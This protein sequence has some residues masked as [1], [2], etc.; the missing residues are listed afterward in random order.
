[1]ARLITLRR[2]MNS[3]W[4]SDYP[5][6]TM[7][8]QLRRSKLY[9]RLKWG[10]RMTLPVVYRPAKS[11]FRIHATAVIEWNHFDT[12][13]SSHHTNRAP[14]FNSSKSHNLLL[15][16]S[17]FLYRKAMRS[18]EASSLSQR[19]YFAGFS[20]IDDGAGNMC[21]RWNTPQRLDQR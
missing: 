21:G 10:F 17:Q 7:R 20:Y 2:T 19:R 16:V 9:S 8:N 13:A 18:C 6:K 1:M 15:R 3:E 4:R 12:S 11:S 5:G 14:D